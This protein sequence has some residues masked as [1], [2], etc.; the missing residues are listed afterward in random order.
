MSLHSS[1]KLPFRGSGKIVYAE[2]N[3]DC[4]ALGIDRAGAH[5]FSNSDIKVQVFS[6]LGECSTSYVPLAIIAKII[7]RNLEGSLYSAIKSRKRAFARPIKGIGAFIILNRKLLGKLCLPI[8][9]AS[10]GLKGKLDGLAAELGRKVE[11]LSYF[12][13]S[14]LM[15]GFPGSYFVLQSMIVGKLGGLAELQHCNYK[16]FG[17]RNFQT[18]CGLYD[19]NYQMPQELMGWLYIKKETGHFRGNEG[20]NSSHS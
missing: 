20:R 6:N 3:P 9:Q 1:E 11:E 16:A 5:L 18:Y 8:P 10:L 13:V 17:I 2:V 19:H 14:S 4:F 15:E 12:L 7:L